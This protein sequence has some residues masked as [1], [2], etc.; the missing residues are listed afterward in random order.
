MAEAEVPLASLVSAALAQLAREL[1]RRFGEAVIEMR[2][3]GS[4]ARAE[5]DEESDVDVAVV[6]ERADWRTRREVIDLAT[7]V[8]L[9]FDLWISPTIFDR[10]TYE[11]WREQERPLVMDIERDGVPL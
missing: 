4:F 1:R 11:H 7:D 6:L 8:G 3:F 2:L 10:E 9:P 5:A